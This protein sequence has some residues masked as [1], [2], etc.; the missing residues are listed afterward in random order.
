MVFALNIRAWAEGIKKE[1]T[2]IVVADE[3][4]CKY[5]FRWLNILLAVTSLGM[6]VVNAF[7]REYILMVSTLLFALLCLLNSAFVGMFPHWQRGLH[8]CFAIEA[9]AL[10][11]FFFIS[12]IPDGF[13]SL[14]ICLIP[15]FSLLIFGSKSGSGFCLAALA[16]MIF[17]FWVPAGRALLRYDYSDTFMF[18]F[19]FLYAS[20]YLIALFMEFVRSRTQKQLVASEEKARHL[21]RH[22]ALT[23][24][25][26]RYG[27][28]EVMQSVFAAGGSGRMAM[29]VIDIDDFK[30]INDTY[31]HLAGDR[32]LQSIAQVMSAAFCEDCFYCRWG[33]EEFMAFMC[34]RHDPYQIAE[35]VREKIENT[36]MSCEGREVKVTVSVGVYV[37]DWEKSPQLEK[38]QNEADKCMYEAKEKGKNC[39]VLRSE[40]EGLAI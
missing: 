4:R 40:P 5:M 26:N 17:L 30:R 10:I 13:S 37:T 31:G 24:L 11:A 29:M 34:C 20:V 14:W 15:S 35:N 16:M 25:Y 19:P 22:D 18:R 36:A 32:V 3:M 38:M 33:G 39:V 7:T 1:I 27:F 12:G 23:D 2:T 9:M 21:Y 6:S 28:N 8:I